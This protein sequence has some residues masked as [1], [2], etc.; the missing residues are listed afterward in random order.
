ME[1]LDSVLLPQVGKDVAQHEADGYMRQGG[2][3]SGEAKL[4]ERAGDQGEGLRR[5]M[6]EV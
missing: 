3:E 1:K 6:E 5:T 2:T 4:R